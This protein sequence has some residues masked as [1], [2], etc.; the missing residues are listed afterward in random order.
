M[1]DILQDILAYLRADEPDP[2]RAPAGA[3]DARALEHILRAHSRGAAAGEPRISKKQLLP[4]YLQVKHDDPDRWATWNI[5]EALEARLVALMQMKPRRTASGV[6][7]ITVLTKPGACAGMCAYCP[8]DL[9]MP[10]SYLADEPACQRAERA[11]FDPYLQVSGRLHALIQMGH[12]TDKIELIVLG[13]TWSDYSLAYQTWFMHELFRALNDAEADETAAAPDPSAR[14]FAMHTA[15]ERRAFYRNAGFTNLPEQRAAEVA[16]AQRQVREG[17]TTYNQAVAELYGPESAW[18]ALTARQQ[19]TA[20]Q[21][22]AQQHANETATHRVVGLV[23]ETRPDAIDV[24][25]LTRLRRFGCTK[26]QI[27]V[28]STDPRILQ[29]NDRGISTYRIGESFAL[30]RL[31]GFKIHAHFMVNLYGSTPDADRADYLRFV[32]DASYEPDEVKLYP[33]ALV[34]GTKLCAHFA[35]GS[36]QPYSERDL[37]DV[38]VDDTLA[39]PPYVRISRMIRDISAH[40][41][42]AGNKKVNL[43]QM[44]EGEIARRGQAIPEIRAREISTA[45]ADTKTLQLQT[46]CYETTVSHERFL[47]WVTPEGR[48]AGFLRLSLP[49]P[50]AFE[51]RTGLPVRSDEAM[52]REVHVYGRVAGLHRS[53]TGAQHHGL[54]RQLV[55]HACTAARQS[56]YARIN[57]ISSV[58]TR[59][60]YRGLGFS[61]GDLYQYKNL[62]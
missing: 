4:Y 28:Q 10:K 8:N 60:Y 35:E 7:T 40:D 23:V 12:V 37:V 46:V 32:T 59:A 3:S 24:E 1:E 56:G 44:V 5:D 42:V 16:E 21:L 39:T 54:G 50:E 31:F 53:G 6:A 43:R 49:L 19:A 47:Q 58:G 48:I 11:Y 52:I 17:L 51:E 33:C 27:G 15:P 14:S 29:M 55:E 62:R 25:Q 18:G 13:G 22:I 57:V 34:A 30:L 61:D 26:I 36:W 41:I 20:D 45:D 2:A 38:L 9:R